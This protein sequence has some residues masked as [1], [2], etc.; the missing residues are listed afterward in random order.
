MGKITELTVT[1]GKTVRA[2]D[3]EEWTRVEYS[4]KTL[5]DS[6]EE[7]NIAKA[8]IEGLIDGWLSS[9]DKRVKAFKGFNAAN[10][11]PKDLAD[12]LAFE[13]NRECIVIK[14]RQ[15][16]SSENFSRIAVIVKQHGGETL[17]PAATRISACQ[18]HQPNRGLADL[19]LRPRY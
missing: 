4:V 9:T 3:R 7:I 1:K 11:F 14:P 2:S 8:H 18:K 5:I 12:M 6:D 16:L 19:K 17:A 13:E 15:Y 10:I